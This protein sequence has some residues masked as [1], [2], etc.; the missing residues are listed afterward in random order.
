MR[1][2]ADEV[3]AVVRPSSSNPLPDGIRRAC[4]DDAGGWHA[5]TLTE[6]LDLSY[7]SQLK[8]YEIEYLIDVPAARLVERTLSE[9]QSMDKAHPR[10]GIW[11]AELELLWPDISAGDVLTL[12]IGADGHSVFYRNGT[13]LGSVD[14]PDFGPHF[15]GIWLSPDSS[16][17]QLRLAL[18]GNADD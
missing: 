11:L 14:D 15:A 6:D 8:G 5:D 1:D 18:T 4:I 2:R 7:R 10:Q 16:R 12:D 9:W 13:L 17:P 3:R